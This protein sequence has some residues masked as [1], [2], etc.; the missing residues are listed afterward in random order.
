MS[1]WI[2]SIGVTAAAGMLIGALVGGSAAPASAAKK[3]K[4]FKPAVP[5]TDSPSAA[6]ARKAKVVKVTDKFTESKPYKVE[7]TH[8]P[9]AWLAADPSDPVNAQTPLV[10]DTKWFNIQVD[11]KK[12]FAGL[13]TRIEW[14]ATPVS[15]MDLYIYDKTG[16]Q[17]GVSGEWN[18]VPG[19]GLYTG[20]G[21]MGYEQVLGMGAA[22][23]GGFTIESRAY[24]SPGEAMTLKVWLGSVR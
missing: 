12:K 3:C 24:M 5:I 21:G 9:A 6:E 1:N 15:D 17:T 18:T 19:T 2:R 13:Y 23:C 4:R 10:E 16:S 7:Y 20:D 14:A 22:D 8:G 11:S